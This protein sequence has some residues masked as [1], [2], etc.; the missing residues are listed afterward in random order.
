MRQYFNNRKS[1]IIQNDNQCKFFQ[2][3]LELRLNEQMHAEVENYS[4]AK[5]RTL[6]EKYSFLRSDIGTLRRDLARFQVEYIISRLV[7]STYLTVIYKNKYI[8]AL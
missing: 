6:T 7:Y 8:Q 3:R 1:T 4:D 5:V 2:T